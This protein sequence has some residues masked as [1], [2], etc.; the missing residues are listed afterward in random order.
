MGTLIPLIK[1]FERELMKKEGLK[2]VQDLN[3]VVIAIG[4]L[5]GV[6]K[7]EMAKGISRELKTRHEIEVEIIGAGSVMRALAEKEGYDQVNLNLFLQKIAANPQ[8]AQEID[9]KVEKDTLRKALDGDDVIIHGRMTPFTVGDWGISIWLT[10][11]PTVI[12]KRISKDPRRAEYGLP[13]K[14]ILKKNVR[15]DQADLAR[16]ERL[17]DINIQ[18]EKKKLDINF[19]TSDKTINES[20]FALTAKVEQLLEAKGLL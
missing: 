5:S 17:Y 15:R 1:D 19:D 9:I 20:V 10:A 7:D 4:G 11:E 8:Y 14:K 6:G 13:P 3:S 16:L 12:S 2:S 18:E